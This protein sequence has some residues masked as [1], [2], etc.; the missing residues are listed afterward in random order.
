M[1]LTAKPLT[2]DE[3]PQLQRHVESWQ[4]IGSIELRPADIMNP[5]SAFIYDAVELF[6]PR[7]AVIIK[8]SGGPWNEPARH[9]REHDCSKHREIIVI[10]RAVDENLPR[11]RSLTHYSLLVFVFCET[12]SDFFDTR[13][14]EETREIAKSILAPDNLLFFVALGEYTYFPVSL[15][16]P[17]TFHFL[18]PVSISFF[19]TSKTPKSA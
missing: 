12:F 1:A 7:F 15:L 11:R 2:G 3:H 10:E 14:S 4:I 5:I 6:D 9:Y 19:I 18:F 16:R 13:D 8:L 17:T